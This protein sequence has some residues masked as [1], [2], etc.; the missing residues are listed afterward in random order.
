MP[1]EFR[2]IDCDADRRRAALDPYRTGGVTAMATKEFR[3]TGCGG[4]F[5]YGEPC[6]EC[7]EECKCAFVAA[8]CTFCEETSPNE[9]KAEMAN[10]EYRHIGCGGVR[11]PHESCSEC[12]RECTCIEQG[13]EGPCRLCEETEINVDSQVVEPE[14]ELDRFRKFFKANGVMF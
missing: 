4:E 3:H 12:G 2:H 8:P 13:R 6:S 10:K 9:A 7:D 14:T 5:D 11:D 1:K